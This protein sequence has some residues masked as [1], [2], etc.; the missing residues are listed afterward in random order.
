M[1]IDCRNKN[2]STSLKSNWLI[3]GN[4]MGVSS[5]LNGDDYGADYDKEAFFEE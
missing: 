1:K 4:N 2:G 3:K 5:N